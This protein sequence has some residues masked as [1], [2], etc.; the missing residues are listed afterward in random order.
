M[1]YENINISKLA[2]LEYTLSIPN[3]INCQVL[4]LRIWLLILSLQFWDR[5]GRLN[6]TCRLAGVLRWTQMKSGS[7][8]CTYLC[9]CLLKA[10]Y[11]LLW[12]VA[13]IK[14][15]MI[16]WTQN[17]RIKAPIV[18][19]LLHCITGHRS[20]RMIRTGHLVWTCY[21]IAWSY[22]QCS[23]NSNLIKAWR[24]II[25]KCLDWIKNLV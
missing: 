21:H 16:F 8:S 23:L 13:L 7:I 6:T 18:S 4:L 2:Y 19:D 20:P 9:L 3:L 5:T 22:W 1:I 24:S 17:S 25:S 12:F 14:C 10:W 15:C 11:M